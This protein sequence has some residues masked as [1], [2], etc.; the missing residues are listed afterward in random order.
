[1]ATTSPMRKSLSSSAA[2]ARGL[3]RDDGAGAQFAGLLRRN[4]LPVDEVPAAAAR[5]ASL[6]ALRRVPSPFGD[7]REAAVLED[8]QLADDAVPPAVFACASRV[9]HKPVTLDAQG[10]RELERLD[11]GVERVRHGHVHAGG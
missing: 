4:L 10:V 8:A 11:R 9:G 6:L 1:M 7:E 3:D 2:A 5:P